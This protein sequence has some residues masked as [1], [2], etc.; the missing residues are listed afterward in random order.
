MFFF[1]ILLLI[2]YFALG[3]T[4]WENGN[5]FAKIGGVII[6]LIVLAFLV[7]NAVLNESL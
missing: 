3:T 6:L 7:I 1:I 2:I 5:I 4:F